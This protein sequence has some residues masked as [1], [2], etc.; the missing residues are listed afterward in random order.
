MTRLIKCT[1]LCTVLVLGLLADARGDGPPF[2]GFVVTEPTVIPLE[3]QDLL[4]EKLK[5]TVQIAGIGRSNRIGSFTT[6]DEFLSV[7]DLAT[8][9]GTIE[10]GRIT[11]VTVLGAELHGTTEGWSEPLPDNEL[12]IAGTITFDGGTRRFRF[13]RG[14]AKFIGVVFSAF[15]ADGNPSED[16]N[17]IYFFDGDLTLKKRP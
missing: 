12:L 4:P 15:D 13:A 9:S 10:D 3:Q 17:G 16:A 8:G 1:L 14:Q 2:Q 11:W 6:D 7:V 5:A